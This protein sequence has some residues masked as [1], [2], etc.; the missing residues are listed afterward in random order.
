MRWTKLSGIATAAVASA[1]LAVPGEIMVASASA[2]SVS[3]ST[4]FAPTD[5]PAPDCET[6]AGNPACP[7]VD[8][9]PPRHHGGS[10]VIVGPPLAP[11]NMPPMAH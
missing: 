2:A 8:P 9:N 11:F 1:L 6:D 4:A 10:P 5:D 3:E 7:P